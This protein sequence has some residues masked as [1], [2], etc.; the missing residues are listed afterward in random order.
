ML[1]LPTAPC[2]VGGCCGVQFAQAC[3]PVVRP[4]AVPLGLPHDRRRAALGRRG[5]VHRGLR[6]R[7]GRVDVARAPRHDGRGRGHGGGCGR[8]RAGGVVGQAGRARLETATEADFFKT[9]VGAS[10]RPQGRRPQ[11][12]DLTQCCQALAARWG[13]WFP[14]CAARRD[15]AGGA[16][17]TFPGS[18]L[19]STFVVAYRY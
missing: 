7:D 10:S 4:G 11:R 12:G 19:R 14:V 15:R 8:S 16:Q 17:P 6:R 13:A 2:S 18:T 1:A 5:E 3:L 9:L